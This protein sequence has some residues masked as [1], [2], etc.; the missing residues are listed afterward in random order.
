MS[1]DSPWPC[2]LSLR[3][4]LG[5]AV[6]AA[7]FVV[8][9]AQD[10]VVLEEKLVSHTESAERQEKTGL[11]VGSQRSVRAYF[12]HSAAASTTSSALIISK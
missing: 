7:S 2:Y 12:Q 10:H 6:K 1:P 11:S 4:P 5:A 8:Q 3:R 9:L